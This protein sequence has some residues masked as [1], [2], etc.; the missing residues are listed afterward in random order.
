MSKK[1][2]N[3][4]FIAFIVLFISGTTVISLYASGFKINRCWPI[5][6]NRLLIRTGMIIVKSQ[7]SGAIVQINGKQQ[8]FFSLN[9]WHDEY[10]STTAKI[11]NVPPGEYVVRLEKEGYWP[12]EK[13][14]N[15]YPNQATTLLDVFLF[16]SD[17]PQMIA[18]AEQ[19]ALSLS[20]SGRLLYIDS[21]KKIISTRTNQETI[22]PENKN[23]AGVWLG[24][25][26]ELLYD[27]QI[28][29][30]SG[31][32]ISDFRALL[33][34]GTKNRFDE[35]TERLYYQKGD[36]IG[37]LNLPSQSA[38]LVMSSPNILT[39]QPQGDKLWIIS[40][41][42]GRALLQS[43]SLPS[44]PL[45]T[46]LELPGVGIYEFKDDSRGEISIYDSQNKT[47]YL[48]NKVDPSLK[49]III[50]DILSWQWVD[51]NTLLYNN[52]WEIFRLNIDTNTSSLL[53]RVGEEIN[54]IIW[55]DENDYLIFSTVDS[56][57]VFNPKLETTT[58]IF[59]A[60]KISAP[61]LDADNNTLYF[62]A[63]TGKK[64]GAFRVLLQ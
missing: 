9:P 60:Q 52:S 35:I 50:K 58:R 54:E 39:Y 46:E 24:D 49:P 55:H 7:P 38:T 45:K 44:G 34:Q 12:W 25:A 20:K 8:T 27:S 13:K 4:L 10:I 64:T 26:N 6:F 51:N 28:F 17:E 18:E 41:E 14:V 59:Q 57:Q 3:W 29:N 31:E 56:L 30:G 53:T 15:V 63:D 32:V 1:I 33:G 22:L 5:Q 21:A 40:A 47:L 48:I 61:T 11:R 36:N 16:R 37:Y 43:F 62:W 42:N 19:G 2:R 23:S